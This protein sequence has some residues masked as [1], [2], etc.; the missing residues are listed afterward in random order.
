MG[1]IG[2]WLENLG[3]GEYS[4]IFESQKIDL[5]TLPYLTEDDLKEMALPIGP[6]RKILV[7]I[8]KGTSPNHTHKTNTSSPT[9]SLSNLTESNTLLVNRN[10]LLAPSCSKS[11]NIC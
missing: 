6:R 1:E 10:T 5:E 7:A 8:S 9:S 11:E 3:L 2:D 4:Q